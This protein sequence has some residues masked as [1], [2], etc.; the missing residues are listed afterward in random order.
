MKYLVTIDTSVINHNHAEAW[1]V[2]RILTVESDLRSDLS[3]LPIDSE[4]M[5][6]FVPTVLDYSN[7][8]SYG[9]A[10]LALRILLRYVRNGRT[11]IEIVLMGNESQEDFLLHYD[12]PNILKIPGIHYSRFNRKVVS[13]YTAKQRT[14]LH[15]SEYKPYLENLGLKIPSSFKS[16]HSLTNEWCLYKWNSFMGL[17]EDVRVLEN[18][19]FFDYLI[20]IEKLDS[21]KN[22]NATEYLKERIE[23]LPQARILL[24]DDKEGWH[25]FFQGIFS[26]SPNIEIQCIGEDFSKLEFK[27]IVKKI[28]DEVNDFNPDIIILDFR[29]MEDKDDE[30]KD[31]M[32]KVSGYKVLSETLKGTSQNPLGSYGRQVIIFTATSRIE[33][34]I[35]LRKGHADGFILKERPENYSGKEITKMAISKMVSLLEDSI[36]RAKFLNPLNCKLAQLD[37]LATHLGNGYKH[38]I[39]NTLYSIRLLTQTN[40]LNDGVLKLTYLNLFSILEGFKPPKV[41]YIDSYIQSNAP[42]EILKYWENIDQL[43]NSLA[44][45][46]NI[47]KFNGE[48]VPVTAHIIKDLVIILCDF[49]KAFINNLLIKTK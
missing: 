41:K 49:I 42:N 37:E 39:V 8:L 3:G 6:W 11:D 24:I 9:G 20:T 27:R 30:I 44:H 38:M 4:S 16:T 23:K 45:G 18:H 43:R 1:C 13:S 5:I 26:N 34:I 29:L 19:L 10:N 17:K 25:H 28:T 7:S 46:D 35:L 22:K 47:V 12:Y 2:D 31:D 48:K 14:Q 36:S 33:N 32:K 21:I 15:V 40:D